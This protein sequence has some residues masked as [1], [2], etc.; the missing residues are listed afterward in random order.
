[1]T[2]LNYFI[3]E[4]NKR[5]FAIDVVILEYLSRGLHVKE[6]ATKMFYSVHTI[7]GRIVKMKETLDCISLCHLVAK[8]FRLKIIE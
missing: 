4:K 1:M 2:G 8:A 5:S 3:G 6:I 7:D